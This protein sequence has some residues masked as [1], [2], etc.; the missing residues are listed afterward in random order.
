MEKYSFNK[1]IISLFTEGIV[2]SICVW[3]KC[4]SDINKTYYRLNIIYFDIALSA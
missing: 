3:K 4:M 1:D 2:N